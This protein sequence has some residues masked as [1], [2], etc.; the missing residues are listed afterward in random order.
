MVCANIEYLRPVLFIVSLNN[1]Q[2]DD[3]CIFT[4]VEIVKRKENDKTTLNNNGDSK[5]DRDKEKEFTLAIK[6][7]L[8]CSV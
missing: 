4:T 5:L 7:L 1:I 8:G 3:T 2:Q 6:K